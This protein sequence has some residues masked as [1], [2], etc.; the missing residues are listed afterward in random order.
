MHSVYSAIVNGY[1]DS[2]NIW[3]PVFC[4]GIRAMNWQLFTSKVLPKVFAMAGYEFSSATRYA[5]VHIVVAAAVVAGEREELERTVLSSYVQLLHDADYGLR[6]TALRN[7]GVVLKA[8]K[9]SEAERLFFG[10]LVALLADTDSSIRFIV[11]D[12]VVSFHKL[13][14]RHRLQKDFVPLLMKEFN[15][16]WEDKSNWLLQNCGTVVKFLMNR[17]L[18]EEKCVTGIKMFFDSAVNTQDAELNKL[19][20][21]SFPCLIDMHFAFEL[22]PSKYVN[23]LNEL[24]IG[25]W[26]QQNVLESLSDIITVYYSHNK[27][28]FIQPILTVFMHSENSCLLLSLMAILAKHAKKLFS[29]ERETL[30]DS[31]RRELLRWL[32]EGWSNARKGLSRSMCAF[33]ELVPAFQKL[34]LVAEYNEYFMKELVVVIRQGNKAEKQVASKAFCL[35]YLKNHSLETRQ[36]LLNQV[37]SLSTSV[38]CFGRQGL[39]YFIEAA[40]DLFSVGFLHRN[41]IVDSYLTLGED[42]V[43]DVRMK[44]AFLA[45]K[46]V[47]ILAQREGAQAQFASILLKLQEDSSREIKRLA[48][49]ARKKLLKFKPR[50]DSSDKA[51]ERQE[52]DYVRTGKEVSL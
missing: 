47:R 39:L 43:I 50:E 18:L 4:A 45:D 13:F 52:E 44:F 27:I 14:S 30:S 6:R 5:A 34:F 51:K 19:A 15:N 32:K 9:P 37:L 8:V 3:Y 11:I 23:A 16:G 38:S 20:I 41:K 28:A 33:I 40:F 31:F 49:D 2:I 25:P 46:A 48:K 17:E 36:E 26:Y 21:K 10:E 7:M 12:I 22:N 29:A 24:A 1:E 35:L 42:R